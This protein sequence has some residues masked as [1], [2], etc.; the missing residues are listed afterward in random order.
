M[1]ELDEVEEEIMD[2]IQEYRDDNFINDF[3][4]YKNYYS[5]A[6]QQNKS[7]KEAVK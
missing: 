3:K 4:T 5:D 2:A 1:P 6:Q 7:L